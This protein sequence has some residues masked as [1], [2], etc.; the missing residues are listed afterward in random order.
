MTIDIKNYINSLY[1]K[2]E[3]DPRTTLTTILKYHNPTDDHDFTVS[4]YIYFVITTYDLHID[5]FYDTTFTILNKNNI[6]EID[7]LES[8][9]TNRNISLNM[10][11]KYLI[12]ILELSLEIRTCELKM[13]LVLIYNLVKKNCVIIKN[14]EIQ[15]YLMIY[16][17]SVQEISSL[18][19]RILKM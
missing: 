12:R 3:E 19:K 15:K 8:I 6:L 10:V 13:V 14:E 11:N 5:D 7:F 9:L 16:S 17:E 4:K 18:S 1:L 2:E